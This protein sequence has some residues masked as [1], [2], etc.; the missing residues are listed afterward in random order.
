MVHLCVYYIWLT[1]SHIPLIYSDAYS[2][3]R[4]M[5]IHS[6]SR[7]KV[8]EMNILPTVFKLKL[9]GKSKVHKRITFPEICTH[10]PNS[11][12]SEVFGLSI[13]TG[14]FSKSIDGAAKGTKVTCFPIAF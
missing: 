8:Y 9:S 6:L 11:N 7:S 1:Q 14:H 5:K 12:Q 4:E 2:L 3:T 13:Q 10:S